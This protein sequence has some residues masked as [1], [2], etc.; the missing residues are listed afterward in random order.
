MSAASTP[1]VQGLLP[2]VGQVLEGSALA[3][4]DPVVQAGERN[5]NR[6]VRWVHVGEVPDIAGLLQGG[7][8]VLTTGIGMPHEPTDLRRYVHDLVAVAAAGL[9]IE[10]GRAFDEL[11]VA[12]ID[13]AERAGLP[14]ISLKRVVRFVAITEEVHGQILSE[15]FEAL[16]AS[17]QAHQ[18]FTTLCVQG[19][20]AADIVHEASRMTGV[21]VVFEN[22]M[23]QVLSYEAREVSPEE[24]LREWETLSR[25]IP[26]VSGTIRGEPADW[27]VTRV[28]ARGEMF[29]RLVALTGP[30][31]SPIQVMTL[32][33]AAIAL[34]LNRL[35]EHHRESL[36]RQAHRSTLTD[37]IEQ[38]YVSQSDMAARAAS[39][40][41]PL[42]RRDLVSIVVDTPASISAPTPLGRPQRDDCAEAIAAAV[43]ERRM[44]ALIGTLREGRLALLLS[45]PPGGS[46]QSALRRLSASIHQR[47]T[48]QE[49]SVVVAVGA[50]VHEIDEVAGAIAEAEHVAT[51]ARGS[52]ASKAFYEL[53]D[54]E[55]RGLLYVLGD[56]PRIQA[57]VERSLGPLLS[58]DDRHQSD[59]VATLRAFLDHSGNKSAAADSAAM[60]RQAFYRRLETIARI[61][62]VDLDS[63]ETCTSLHA[64][65]IA[66]E[67]IRAK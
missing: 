61:L 52:Q 27:L 51:A 39:L 34:T 60:S 53:P 36:E 21:P 20:S 5:L 16:R 64:A 17:E 9:V 7:E 29:G 57:F 45:L 32:E 43:R 2:T 13:A 55:L 67:S 31:P 11:P 23:H 22:L 14:L 3:A 15:Q 41:V 10:L 46:R 42:T 28:E 37:L 62:Q 63:A 44:L 40:G 1:G 30:L 6:R 25:A 18:V 54:I 49:G 4:G 59:L 66:L 26:D 38:R 24:L 33:R 47:F 56:D 12:L 19:A 35:L 48:S 8:L 50:T 65:M 58:Y